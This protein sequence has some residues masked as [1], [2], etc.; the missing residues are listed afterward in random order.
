LPRSRRHS[1]FGP[2]RS[3]DLDLAASAIRPTHRTPRSSRPAKNPLLRL[4][5][6][7][8]RHDLVGLRAIEVL[9][10]RDALEVD[11]EVRRLGSAAALDDADDLVQTYWLSDKGGPSA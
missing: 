3:T 6:V 10:L 7:E 8:V 1:C 2:P 9:R 5:P 11:D 4:V